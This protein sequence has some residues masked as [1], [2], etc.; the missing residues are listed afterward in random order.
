ML[1][2][3]ITDCRISAKEAFHS[4][5]VG[6]CVDG[7]GLA[8]NDGRGLFSLLALDMDITIASPPA[9]HAV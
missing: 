5:A 7:T 4:D 1:V 3:F 8:T 9:G 2:M 6:D